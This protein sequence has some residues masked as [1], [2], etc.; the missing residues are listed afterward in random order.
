MVKEN[1]DSFDP[2]TRVLI[3]SYSAMEAKASLLFMLMIKITPADHQLYW[4]AC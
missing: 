3:Y 2:V 4:L 1:D